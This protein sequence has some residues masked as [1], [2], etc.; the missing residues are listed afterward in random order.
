MHACT[1]VIQMS[2]DSPVTCTALK[3]ALKMEIASIIHYALF[4]TDQECSSMQGICRTPT[5]ALSYT[6]VLGILRPARYMR[7]NL[8][9]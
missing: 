2:S 9:I 6:A 3:T 5:S 8:E 7:E 1:C 4:N